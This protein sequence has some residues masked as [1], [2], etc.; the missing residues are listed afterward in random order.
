MDIRCREGK[1]IEIGHSL[2]PNP[3]EKII[4][5]NGGALLPGLHD[6]HIHLM[7]LAA[8]FQSVNC[9]PPKVT[10]IESLARVLQ[11]A[12]GSGWIRGTGYH[13][14]VAGL[15]DRRQLD[16]LMP[17]RPVRIQHRSGKMWL[18]NTLAANLLDLDG[19]RN[20]DGVEL[21]SN[22]SPTGRLFRLD[23]WLRQ[24]IG[25]D[26]LPDIKAASMKLASFGVTGI[27]D[28]TADNSLST[29][30]FI[31]ELLTSGDLLQRTLL[32]GDRTLISDLCHPLLKT[33]SLKILL[34]DY[35]LPDFEDLKN[36]IADTHQQNRSVAIHCVTATEL[37]FALSAIR[38]A[39]ILRGDRIEHA[40]VIPQDAISL[41]KD[42]AVT[43]VTQPA[44]IAERG[45]QYIEDITE[46]E[47]ADLYRC[48]SLTRAGIPVG[49]STD[50]PFGNPDPWH[51]MRA[52]VSRQTASGTHLGISETL[53]PED[54][55]Q[56]FTSS[57]SDPGGTARAIQVGTNADLCL[58]NQPW[59]SA[60][61]RL[62]QENVITTIRSG[63]IIFQA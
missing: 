36:M 54:A 39:G 52:A 21:D 37:I 23:D 53:T 14:S 5:A 62:I 8:S 13:E 9:G 4:E 59:L 29:L 1:I 61:E 49:G 47:H 48:G 33:G 60:R 42:T 43:V 30:C 25:I 31:R 10:T 38:E 58:L 11:G 56:L 26:T 32:M 63:E 6:H 28:A 51:A 20:M 45:D 50:A 44:F 57:S 18:V 2:A 41:I 17:D 27:T 24:K 19:H 55:L 16:E 40:S 7:A 3:G 15:L 35:Q 12:S 46:A 22:N 34:D